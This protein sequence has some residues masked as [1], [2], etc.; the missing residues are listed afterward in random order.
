M[1][2]IFAD[3]ICGYPHNILTLPNSLRYIGRDSFMDNKGL[4]SIT[5]PN[6]LTAIGGYAF[7]GCTG[8]T[9]IIKY[10]QKQPKS[11]T[12]KYKSKYLSE[13]KNENGN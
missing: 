13:S 8:L 3:C 6:G 12:I 5:I 9:S 10:L 11:N 4:S 2:T 7:S 1:Y